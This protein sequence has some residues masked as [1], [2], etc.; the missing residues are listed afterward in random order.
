[1]MWRRLPASGQV[2]FASWSAQRWQR[3]EVH[4]PASD[5]FR[6]V[7]GSWSLPCLAAAI[8]GFDTDIAGLP[9][10]AQPWTT[11]SARTGGR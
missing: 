5:S 2:T 3:D 7:L 11:C 8:G 10:T 6:L 9:A 4:G 1:M